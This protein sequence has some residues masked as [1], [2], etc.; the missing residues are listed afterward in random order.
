M[1]SS[2][3]GADWFFI[4]T[5]VEAATQTS[6]PVGSEP[7]AAATQTVQVA[8]AP[9]LGNTL[10]AVAVAGVVGVSAGALFVHWWTGRSSIRVV[11]ASGPLADSGGAMTSPGVASHEFVPQPSLPLEDSLP[12]F[13]IAPLT[14]LEPV[15]LGSWPRLE[16]LPRCPAPIPECFLPPPCAAPIPEWFSSS[17]ASPNAAASQISRPLLAAAVVGLGFAAL[18]SAGLLGRCLWKRAGIGL[19][20]QKSSVGAPKVN[21]AMMLAKAQESRSSADVKAFAASSRKVVCQMSAPLS[22]EKAV[23]RWPAG[24]LSG[25][26]FSPDPMDGGVDVG[27]EILRRAGRTRSGASCQ[28]EVYVLGGIVGPA[29]PTSSHIFRMLSKQ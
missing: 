26:R 21:D 8:T 19:A 14:V 7:V 12:Y 20:V 23:G 22:K 3:E 28:A 17:Q 1:D 9:C 13:A 27:F 15:P 11:P 18:A 16:F 5:A 10:A 25:K 24:D 4:G 2:G 6:L 29:P